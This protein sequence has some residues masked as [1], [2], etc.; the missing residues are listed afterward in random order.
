MQHIIVIILAAIILLLV[1]V[2]LVQRK[3]ET[4]MQV[5]INGL[6]EQLETL[7]TTSAEK[8]K[9]R[10]AILQ[11]ANTIYLYAALSEEEAQSRSLRGKQ[12]AIRQSSEVIIRTMQT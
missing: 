9:D 2:L 1:A 7:E 4:N 3:K 5:Q 8:L 6:K 12:A 11:A 10:E